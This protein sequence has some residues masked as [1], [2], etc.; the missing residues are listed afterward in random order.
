MTESQPE[1]IHSDG[2]QNSAGKAREEKE[3][4]RD[5]GE[6]SF[7]SVWHL[8][9]EGHYSHKAHLPKYLPFIFVSLSVVCSASVFFL[10]LLFNSLLSHN[11]FNN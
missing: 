5:D 10:C 3:R 4:R 2:W 8:D 11:T 1:P 7:P 6:L 9:D